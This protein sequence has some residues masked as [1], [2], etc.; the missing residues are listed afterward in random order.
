MLPQGYVVRS[1]PG[2]ALKKI[3]V[4]YRIEREAADLSCDERRDN[5]HKFRRF[6]DH[7][8]ESRGQ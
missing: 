4:L 3:K 2:V 8:G 7:R 1:M 5:K 6:S